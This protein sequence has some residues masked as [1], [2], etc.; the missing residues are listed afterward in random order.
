[1]EIEGVE[2]AAFVQPGTDSGAGRVG[3]LLAFAVA[4]GWDREALRAKLKTRLDPAFLPRRLV[5]VD[6]LPRN[7]TGKLL[8]QDL[9][10]LLA[11]HGGSSP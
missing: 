5:L 2:D 6:A 3:R 1:M 9:E 11:D 7:A 8:R 4:P 10:Q